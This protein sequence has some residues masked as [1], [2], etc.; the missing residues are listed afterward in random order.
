VRTPS[1]GLHAYFTGSSRRNGHL[2]GHHLDFRSAGGY[3]LAPPSQIDG[4]PYRL[5]KTAPGHGGLDW[6]AVTQLLEPQRQHQRPEPRQALDRDVTHLAR[7]VA[8]QPEGNRNAGLFWAANRALAAEASRA[9]TGRQPEPGNTPGTPGQPQQ[10]PTRRPGSDRSTASPG[11]TWPLPQCA[12]PGIDPGTG[13]GARAVA[14]EQRSAGT[15]PDMRPPQPDLGHRNVSRR[16][17]GSPQHAPPRTG[18]RPGGRTVTRETV[19]INLG[20]RGDH[21]DGPPDP[22]QDTYWDLNLLTP[23][24]VCALL[25]VKKS[26]LYDAVENGAIEAIRLGKQL[27]FR[28]SA[29]VRYLEGRVRNVNY[30]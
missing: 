4:K 6:D 19:T 30:H 29:L 20:R 5:I 2:P 10:S 11:S 26:W 7:W 25:K 1:G 13:P 14:A 16:G 8:S 21:A 23:D 22:T 12:L 17:L 3:I 27:R 15:P 28:P 24:D 9:A 18:G